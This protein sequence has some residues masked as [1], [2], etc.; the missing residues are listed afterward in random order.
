MTIFNTKSVGIIKVIT[1]PNNKKMYYGYD[2]VV[3]GN[4]G[5]KMSVIS[6]ASGA[7][8]WRGLDY[9][10]N[11]KIINLKKINDY[12]YTSTAIGTN[13]YNIYLDVSHPRKSTCTC[14]LAME[15]E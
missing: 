13:N 2:K 10:K 8:C 7:S 12:E 9:Y 14:P 6:S 1:P 4:G 3:R 11:N 15:K 5:A